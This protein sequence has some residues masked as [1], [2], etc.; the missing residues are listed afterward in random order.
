MANPDV[1][2]IADIKGVILQKF[3]IIFDTSNII[4][5]EV[6]QSLDT[7]YSCSVVWQDKNKETYC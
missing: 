1:K 2:S 5:E 3:F 7:N 4:L 6:D